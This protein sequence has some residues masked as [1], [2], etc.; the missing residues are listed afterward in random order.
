MKLSKKEVKKIAELA[1]IELKEEEIEKYREQLS[2]IL[3]YVN[4][5]QEVDTAGAEDDWSKSPILNAWRE[6]EVRSAADAERSLI[7]E[8]MPDK[9][10]DLLK[11]IGIFKK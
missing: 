5:L 6:D 1:K 7:L 10:G 9:E 11:T 3:E 4:K 8:N 2:D